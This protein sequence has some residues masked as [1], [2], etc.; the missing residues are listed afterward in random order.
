MSFSESPSNI[1]NSTQT[2]IRRGARERKPRQLL[3]SSDFYTYTGK[4]YERTRLNEDVTDP[5]TYEQA[6]LDVDFDKWKSTMDEEMDSMYKNEIWKLV[7]PPTL[8]KLIKCKWIFTRKRNV[9]GKVEKFKARLVAKGFTQQ[10]KIDYDEIF[11][12]VARIQSIR[13]L[14]ALV[15]Y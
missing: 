15:A 12:S 6:L 5:D 13:A 4:T 7:D 1:E 8:I 3:S 14:L 10:Y 11:S 9:E 2:D